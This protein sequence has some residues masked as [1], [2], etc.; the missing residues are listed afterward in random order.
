MGL[1][2]ARDWETVVRF[3]WQF[4]WSYVAV[5]AVLH[6]LALGS[7][8]LP[9]H[10]MIRRL[11]GRRDW[12][13]DFRIYSL[14]VLARRIPTP[15]WYVGGRIYLYHER[16]VSTAIVLSASGL[17]AVLIGLSGIICY[18]LLLPW[19][20]YTQE[21]PWQVIL[22][23]GAA[24]AIMLVVR[25]N[26]LLDLANMGL[27]LL[28]RPPVAAAIDR[29]SLG[30]WTLTYL[31]TWFLDGLGLY[32]VVSAL[33]PVPPPLPDVIGVSTIYALVGLAAMILPGGF[34]LKELAMGAML[35]MWI[36]VSAGIAVSIFYRLAQTFIEAFWA[37]VGYRLDQPTSRG[38]GRTETMQ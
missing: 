13:C 21:W 23:V 36:P 1:A 12:R 19:Y 24:V 22:A 35:S 31:A 16:N 18:V 3:P 29:S 6:S 14:S 8:F 26:L 5:F 15:L 34:G 33:L 28:R 27:R 30:L 9:W 17:E 37:L 4:E 20:S 32:F 25:P 38:P 10:Q 7:L 2:V 11:T